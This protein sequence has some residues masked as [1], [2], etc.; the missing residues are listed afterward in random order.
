MDL[1]SALREA[2]MLAAKKKCKKCGKELSKNPTAILC[3][4]CS[5]RARYAKIPMPAFVVNESHLE[6]VMAVRWH[7]HPGG[8]LCGRPFGRR[9]KMLMHAYVWLLEYGK[10]PA[11]MI[12]HINR[13]K[14]DNRIENLRLASSSLNAVN[15]SYTKGPMPRGVS[16]NSHFKSKPYQAGIKR[17][18]RYCY[19]GCYASTEEAAAKCEDARQIIE[20][21]E[22]LLC[23]D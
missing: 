9:H 18:G 15:S 5:N 20:E 11:R 13:D 6:A 19:L 14:T 10:K 16:K 1:L 7:H 2:L 4:S 21:F 8:Y 17:R 22:A 23:C 3:R 12:D